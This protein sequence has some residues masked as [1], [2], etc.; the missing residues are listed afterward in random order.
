[1]KESDSNQ[2]PA[3]EEEMFLVHVPALV[4]VLLNREHEKG[5]PLTEVDVL[6]ITGSSACIAMPLHAKK[7]VEESRGYL[8]I[9]PENAW[10]EWQ[11]A[12]VELIGS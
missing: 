4:A 3:P 12:R 9:N 5:S 6:E 10:A 7:K 2:A 11:A 8:D 1:M